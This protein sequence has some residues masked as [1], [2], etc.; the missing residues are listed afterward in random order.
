MN[1][2]TTDAWSISDGE[3]KLIVN[4]NGEEELFNLVN[5]PYEQTN[6]LEGTLTNDQIGKKNELEEELLKIRN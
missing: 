1:N 6:L 2:D 5:D 4:S 3:Y